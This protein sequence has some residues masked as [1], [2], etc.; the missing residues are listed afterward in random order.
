MTTLVGR[1]ITVRVEVLSVQDRSQV[2][3]YPAIT[4]TPIL[5]FHAWHK[6]THRRSRNEKEPR[7]GMG[8]TPIA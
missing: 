4:E 6:K 7:E 1:H 3:A 2:A 5:A 8:E